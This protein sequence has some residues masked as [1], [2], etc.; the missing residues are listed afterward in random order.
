MLLFSSC[1]LV[2]MALYHVEAESLKPEPRF[3]CL[4]F[5]LCFIC[6]RLLAQVSEWL[7]IAVIGCS[8]SLLKALNLSYCRH[9][10]N[11]QPHGCFYKSSLPG[12][13][14]DSFIDVSR[15][16]FSYHSGRMRS[17]DRNYFGPI[18]CT[19]HLCFLFFVGILFCFE[20][21]LY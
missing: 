13:K 19:V 16:L 7:R 4:F 14:P 2:Y 17:S 21:G 1:C 6:S 15:W 3:R 11:G 10:Q 18:M 9:W 8:L 20:V 12:I 5:T